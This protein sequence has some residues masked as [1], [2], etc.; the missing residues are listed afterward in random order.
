LICFKE[1]FDY[2]VSLR[3]IMICFK[4]TF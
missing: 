1:V 4:V 3:L 2:L